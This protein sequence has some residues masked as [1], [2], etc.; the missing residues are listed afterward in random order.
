MQTV[1]EFYSWLVVSTVLKNISHWEGLSQVLRKMKKCVKPPTSYRFCCWKSEPLHHPERKR[2]LSDYAPGFAR[3]SCSQSWRWHQA[4]SFQPRQRS[5]NVKV[6]QSTRSQ[7]IDGHSWTVIKCCF[8]AL[9]KQCHMG[10]FLIH[11]TV[12]FGRRS[13]DMDEMEWVNPNIVLVSGIPYTYP[14]EKWWSQLGW[15]FP[16][17]WKKKNVPNHQPVIGSDPWP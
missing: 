5:G 2:C 3:A 6:H 11:F 16:T 9:K 15:L 17:E 1:F 10:Q 14:S 12:I 8:P 4:T 13:W 7:K